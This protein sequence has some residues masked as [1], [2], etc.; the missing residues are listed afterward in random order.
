MFC[1]YKRKRFYS[2]KVF[3]KFKKKKVLIYL[4]RI[5]LDLIRDS[6]LLSRLNDQTLKEELAFE[7]ESSKRENFMQFF[8]VYQMN[9]KIDS[10][11]IESFII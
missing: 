5:H 1:L 3:Y 9:V 8:Y 10:K 11:L 6:C 2:D 7:R 4:V